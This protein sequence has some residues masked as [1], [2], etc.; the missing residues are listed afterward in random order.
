[1]RYSEFVQGFGTPCRDDDDLFP[2]HP[3]PF[4][5]AQRTL[6][7]MLDDG[8]FDDVDAD[9]ASEIVEKVATSDEFDLDFD[10]TVKLWEWFE[11]TY[12]LI[13]NRGDSH[14]D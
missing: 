10:N 9:T 11:S 2:D 4:S 13:R 3:N 8:V 14:E 6:D 1:M 5:E 7:Q 12:E